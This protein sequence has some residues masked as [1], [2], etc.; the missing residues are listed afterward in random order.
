M[1]VSVVGTSTRRPNAVRGLSLLAFILAAGGV[2]ATVVVV[3]GSDEHPSRVLWPLVFAP[4][5]CTAVAVSVP[6]R[7]AR[8]S[9]AVALVAWCVVAAASVGL[10]FVPA[11]VVAV[12]AAFR[13][14]GMS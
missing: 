10:F 5:I 14:G 1:G 11:A 12:V 6:R 4:L 8:I 9:A 2:I 3:A 7:P 13:R